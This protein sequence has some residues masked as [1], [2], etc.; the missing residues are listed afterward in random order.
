MLSFLFFCCETDG[1]S[2]AL[3][4]FGKENPTDPEF[5]CRAVQLLAEVS[6]NVSEMMPRGANGGFEGDVGPAAERLLLSKTEVQMRRGKGRT[7]AYLQKTLR[8]A[9]GQRRH[10]SGGGGGK[11]PIHLQPLN[12][13]ELKAPKRPPS[14]TVR[15][16]RK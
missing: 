10:R 13:A 9:E 8:E 15:S 12:A 4:K 11:P 7:L 6:R 14:R 1:L 5:Q 16:T 3:L 2:K